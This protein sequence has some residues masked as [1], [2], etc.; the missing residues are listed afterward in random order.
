MLRPLCDLLHRGGDL[1]GGGVHLLRRSREGHG[2]TCDG[3]G[4]RLDLARELSQI[5]H[6][7]VKGFRQF[8]HLVGGVHGD[9]LRQ[10]SLR[11]DPHGRRQRSDLGGEALGHDEG[12]DQPQQGTEKAR[13]DEG[14]L[15]RDETT[16]GDGQHAGQNGRQDH[17]EES[18]V[19]LLADRRRG[20]HKVPPRG[21]QTSRA[22]APR[23]GRAR[24]PSRNVK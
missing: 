6:H 18:E 8:P 22:I 24:T 2:G 5:P 15:L 13:N 19:H 21:D 11:H 1:L 4:G 16:E 10:V 12:Q 7:L 20:F 3:I 14:I 17:R 9:I 23:R